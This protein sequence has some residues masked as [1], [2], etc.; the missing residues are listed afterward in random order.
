MK[1]LQQ[2]NNLPLIGVVVGVLCLIATAT[3]SSGQ[4]VQVDRAQMARDQTFTSP[5]T[6]TTPTGEQT[7]VASPNDPDLGDQQI[8]RRMKPISRL[9][10]RCRSRCT[11]RR[12]WR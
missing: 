4:S 1:T 2:H 6:N 7:V 8:L 5:P 9:W 3:E 11:G 10:R 12:M